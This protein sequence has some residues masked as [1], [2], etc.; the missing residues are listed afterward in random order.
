MDI[1]LGCLKDDEE[2][3]KLIESTFPEAE[4]YENFS[5]SGMEE[6]ICYI[7]PI[8]ASIIPLANFIYSY[9]AKRDD[10]E[11]N[12]KERYVM[13]SGKKKIFKG[14]TKDEIIE[15]LGKIK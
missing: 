14:Y 6:N 10:K 12:D 8:V 5:V 9:I 1:I 4:V 15:I 11:N 13:I 2:F 7:I 3:K